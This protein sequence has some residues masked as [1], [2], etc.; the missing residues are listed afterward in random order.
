MFLSNSS[1]KSYIHVNLLYH[2]K[3]VTIL[4][5]I[6]VSST[7]MP[8]T[9]ANSN[10]ECGLDVLNIRNEITRKLLRC[11]RLMYIC[12]TCCH[13][14]KDINTWCKCGQSGDDLISKD[15]LLSCQGEGAAKALGD[16][17]HRQFA[18]SRYSRSSL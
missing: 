7:S 12:S 3:I 10:C 17:E 4:S 9:Q 8:L 16:L 1:F 6:V 5:H 15:I 14:Y 18:S 13:L 2:I 11:K